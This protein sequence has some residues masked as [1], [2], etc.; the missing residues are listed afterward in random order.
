MIIGN[1]RGEVLIAITT[2]KITV[3]FTENYLSV[4]E[5]P[6]IEPGYYGRVFNPF[7]P[8]QVPG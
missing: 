8:R 3:S 6:G 4:V 1:H 5:M 7:D 2:K